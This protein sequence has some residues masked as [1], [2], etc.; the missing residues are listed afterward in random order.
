MIKRL[1]NSLTFRLTFLFL[2]VSI[3]ALGFV[4]ICINRYISQYATTQDQIALDEK[5]FHFNQ[6][7][8]DIYVNNHTLN[9]NQP[10]TKNQALDK[11]ERNHNFIFFAINPDGKVLYTNSTNERFN[12]SFLNQFK[13]DN[14]DEI[15]MWNHNHIFYRGMNGIVNNANNQ[16]IIKLIIAKDVSEYQNFFSS[17]NK[18]MWI[19]ILIAIFIMGSSGWIVAKNGLKPLKKMVDQTS[20]IDVNQLSMRLPAKHI[21]TEL[22]AL[23]HTLNS[24]LER[25]E[26]SFSRLSGF[27]S[28]LAHELRTPV[29]TLKMQTQVTLSQPRTNEEYRDVLYSNAEEFDHLS[30]MISDILFLAKTDNG[31]NLPKP[32]QLNLRE[33]IQ[34]VLDFYLFIAEEKGNTFN[35]IGNAQISG[36]AIMLKRA[37]SN[38]IMNAIT[39]SYPDSDIKIIIEQS[40]EM[41]IISIKNSGETITEE[42]LP[43]LFSR[44]YRVNDSR[45]VASDGVGLGLAITRSIIHAHGGKIDVS[46][47]NENTCFTIYLPKH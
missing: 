31:L 32:S 41:N 29:N 33:E 45:Q 13:N 46:S 15:F 1:Y 18:T 23:S 35:I 47:K 28:D 7:M 6:V 8:T 20:K 27:S 17:C 22:A 11:L 40:S 3:F 24:M 4:G 14:T 10:I 16:P 39:Y 2:I 30:Q 37:L 12:D 21:P 38:L 25:L 42:H 34:K 43:Y 26:N 9:L 19:S 44:F 36:D 5:M